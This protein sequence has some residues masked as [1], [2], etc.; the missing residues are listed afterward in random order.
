MHQLIHDENPY[1]I[2]T[3]PLICKANQLTGF[4][5]AETSVTKNLSSLIQ[6]T[7]QPVLGQFSLSIPT[8]N[9]KPEVFKWFQG[10]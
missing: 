3:S 1:L 2:E 7:Y 6:S 4:Y 10:V 8:E 9:R 5:M